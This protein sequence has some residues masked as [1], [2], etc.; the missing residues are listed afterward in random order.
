MLSF[1]SILKY[2]VGFF[3]TESYCPVHMLTR[4]CMC[5]SEDWYNNVFFRPVHSCVFQSRTCMCA[6]DCYMYVLFCPVCA[7][8]TVMSMCSSELTYV[9]QADVSRMLYLCILQT[10]KK[11]MYLL[12]R[13]VPIPRTGMHSS[14]C[15]LFFRY[16]CVLQ[17]CLC[18]LQTVVCSSD[19]FVF[20][21][22][23]CVLEI[24]LCSSVCCLFFNLLCV[25]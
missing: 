7:L 16:V 17:T 4:T 3:S 8:Q 21:R 24:C 11:Q 10:D 12:F 13:V 5:S 20:F 25:L 18:V 14:D 23:L 6:T 22:L 2:H 1:S 19:L 9:L 15:S